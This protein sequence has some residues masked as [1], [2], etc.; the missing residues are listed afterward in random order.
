[1]KTKKA[2]LCFFKIMICLGFYPMCVSAWD[3][4]ALLE[5]LKKDPEN[6]EAIF[7]LAETY[8]YSKQYSEAISWHKK[9]LKTGKN[10]E[11]TWNSKCQLGECYEAID[12]WSEALYWYLEAHQ[13]NPGRHEPLLKIAT[14]Y[15]QHGENNLAYIFAKHGSRFSPSYDYHFDQELSIVSFYTRF[16][17]D[18]YKA[19]SD[20]LL[21]R[22]APWDI[23]N[24]AYQNILFYCQNLKNARFQPI[25]PDL[26]KIVETS[27]ERYH[28]MNP[29]FC[30]VEDGYALICRSVNYTQKGAKE[31][32][33]IDFD[34][35]I[36]TRNFLLRYT[37]DFQLLSQ[38]EIK[39][40][41]PQERLYALNVLGLEDARIFSHLGSLWFTCT[42]RE[43]TIDGVPQISLCKI[44]PGENV[45]KMVLLN[46]P[47]PY[48]CEKNW[49]PF[50]QEDGFY[51]VY[52][53]DPFMI[54]KPDM[55]T[56]DCELALSY[57]PLHDFSQFRGSAGPIPFEGG[58]L[59]LIHEI[60]F[61]PDYSRIYLHRFLQLDQRFYVNRISKPFT[62]MHQG[63]E[64][65][66]SMAL[67][68]EETQL[69]L[70]VGIEDAKAYL[71]FLD[72]NTL[73]SLLSPLQNAL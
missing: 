12:D 49:L 42:S 9:L 10:S 57:R 64:F 13:M 65:C 73:K 56:G 72:L 60:V 68:H 47:D 30:K 23:K 40:D 1:M 6:V 21:R 20:L 44:G 28:P 70:S 32:E 71:C 19:A 24:Q 55:E 39:E 36:R 35:K 51:T 59:L 33:T 29:S 8:Y 52:S 53:Y 63:V 61:Q 7:H 38:E 43:N 4:Q 54:Y 67:N 17:E 25:Q 27:E 50:I 15:R 31:F 34:G 14:Y 37:K 3:I 62:F 66:G 26:P 45:E 48:R 46:G 16:K 69:V 18:G 11:Q 5:R 2:A 22:D 58:Y 41:L